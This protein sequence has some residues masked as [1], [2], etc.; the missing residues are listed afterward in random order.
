M[1]FPSELQTASKIDR[2]SGYQTNLNGKVLRRYLTVERFRDVVLRGVYFPLAAQFS[3]EKELQFPSE[4]YERLTKKLWS[5]PQ[6][7]RLHKLE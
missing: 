4:A 6:N 7:A 1:T 3:D 5:L 2:W